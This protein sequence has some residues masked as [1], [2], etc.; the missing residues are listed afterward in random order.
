MAMSH[1]VS[2]YVFCTYKLTYHIFTKVYEMFHLLCIFCNLMTQDMFHKRVPFYYQWYV[3]LISLSHLKYIGVI[4]V[5]VIFYLRICHVHGRLIIQCLWLITERVVLSLFVCKLISFF[6]F[7][8]E[9]N[10]YLQQQH[11]T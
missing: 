6:V 9:I 8:H 1:C 2:R 7:D 11:L 4:L 10:D 3:C 5:C